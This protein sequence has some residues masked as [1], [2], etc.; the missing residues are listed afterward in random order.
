MLEPDRT[1]FSADPFGYSALS[2][3]K[4]DT[5]RTLAGYQAHPKAF[6]TSADLKLPIFWLTQAHALSEAA[7][8]VL[9]KQPGWETMPLPVRSICDSQYCAAGLMLIGYSIEICLKGML[10]LTKGIEG[11]T[12]EENKFQHHKLDR[13]AYQVPN[14]TDKDRAILRVL[15]HFTEWA[16]RYPDPGSGRHTKVEEVFSLSEQH[17]ITSQDLFALAVHVM[18]HAQVVVNEYTAK[19][20][21]SET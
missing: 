8:T 15:T 20:P 4:W 12:N 14:L 10:L 2:W 16:G 9:S 13:L 21:G 7:T 19:E 18:R 11:Y 17:Q 5:A 6:P 1:R 3:H